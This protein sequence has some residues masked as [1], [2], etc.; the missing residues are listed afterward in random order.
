MQKYN[1]KKNMLED[2]NIFFNGNNMFK[3]KDLKTDII[4]E[5]DKYCISVDVPGVDRDLINITFN[6]GYLTISVNKT[7][8][9]EDNI[10]YLK[11]ERTSTSITRKY[12][13]PDID[14]A[15]IKAKLDNG[16]LNIICGKTLQVPNKNIK[17]E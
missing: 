14:D 16:V 17:I 11:R 7:E 2:I 13:L 8:M 9:I 15:N 6:D 3:I 5:K 4:E 1:D 10:N 12:Y